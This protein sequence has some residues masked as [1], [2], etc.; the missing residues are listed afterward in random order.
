MCVCSR[1]LK[2]IGED[3]KKMED[4]IT[5]TEDI[6]RRERQRDREFYLRERHRKLSE[7]TTAQCQIFKV[8]KKQLKS[9]KQ[10]LE[11]SSNIVSISPQSIK[12]TK[13][14]MTFR[15]KLAKRF[16]RKNSKSSPKNLFKSSE[17]QSSIKMKKLQTLKINTI[18]EPNR[19]STR[20][21]PRRFKSRLYFRNGKIGCIDAEN[22][23]ATQSNIEKTHAIIK[24]ITND[25]DFVGSTA[26]RSSLTSTMSDILSEE[27]SES[28]DELP[29]SN[30]YFNFECSLTESD[31]HGVAEDDFCVN[32]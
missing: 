11:K 4:L 31:D 5:L 27:S 20:F 16:E 12:K 22:V 21:S 15:Q 2:E 24:Y 10:E 28:F 17:N 8:Q 30:S 25:V 19:K 9:P 26:K 13:C 23:N 3:M 1:S 7:S 18:Y 29:N 6:I 14:P 32:R